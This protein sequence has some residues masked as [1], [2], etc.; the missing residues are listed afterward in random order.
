MGSA[1]SRG[2]ATNQTQLL[3]LVSA[4]SHSGYLSLKANHTR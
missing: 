4:A 1:D 2:Q 3:G